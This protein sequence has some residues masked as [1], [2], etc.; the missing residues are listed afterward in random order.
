MWGNRGHKRT[1]CSQKLQKGKGDGVI[2]FKAPQEESRIQYP[3]L[4]TSQAEISTSN[5]NQ[6][7]FLS[8]NEKRQNY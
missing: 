7:Y 5:G 8:E 6:E 1:G 4:G 3:C 2:V